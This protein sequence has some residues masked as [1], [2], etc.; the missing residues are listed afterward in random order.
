MSIINV[1]L[2]ANACIYDAEKQENNGTKEID[3][4]NDPHPRFNVLI[5]EV[6]SFSALEFAAVNM[7]AREITA[8]WKMLALFLGL[9]HCVV[10]EIDRY[11]YAKY[12]EKAHHAL[13]KWQKRSGENATKQVLIKALEDVHR[14]DIADE[15]RNM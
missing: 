2:I 5:Y 13:R 14:K 6:N 1:F 9:E 15:L 4:P 7:V 3:W 12:R 8:D 11:G 10:E